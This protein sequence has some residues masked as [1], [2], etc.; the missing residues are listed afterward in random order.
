MAKAGSLAGKVALITGASSGIG[1]ATAKA[2]AAAGAR[3][4]LAARRHVRLLGIVDEIA[5][6]GGQ[7][8]AVAADIRQA[9]EIERLL[10]EITDW[11][12]HLDIL[13]NNAATSPLARIADSTV[14]DLRGML[15]TNLAAVVFMTRSALPALRRAGGDIV[16]I[17]SVAVKVQNPG[18]A[19]YAATKA[20]VT[21]FSESLRKEVI[22]DKIRVS[23]IH[24][25]L[26]LTG[27]ANTFP[28]LAIR[29]RTL[30]RLTELTPLSPEDIA[31]IIVFILT[32]PAHVAIND[33]L[34]R[35]SEQE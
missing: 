5:A 34:V 4:V 13:V 2:L 26:V 19:T 30:N 33:I 22:K 21:A 17:G 28:D 27:I 3:V 24:P 6:N 29:E 31:E 23:V 15:D 25:G 20:A 9:S 18:S 10:R 7:A 1:A 16:N 14:E 11:G 8:L 32:R 35:P 12:G